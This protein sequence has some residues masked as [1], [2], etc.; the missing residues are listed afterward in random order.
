VDL[1]ENFGDLRKNGFVHLL[2]ERAVRCVTLLSTGETVALKTYRDASKVNGGRY[3]AAQLVRLQQQQQFPFVVRLL[4]SFAVLPTM[5]EN[6]G[7]ALMLEQ[8]QALPSLSSMSV[9]LVES[10]TNQ[11][12]QALAVLHQHSIVHM[13]IKPANL[14]L[15]MDSDVMNGASSVTLKL[16]DF[17]FATVLIPHDGLPVQGT[18]GY[19][20]PELQGKEKK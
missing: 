16:I 1:E 13:D 11:L 20:A 19:I 7:Y 3:E 9:P 2:T 15:T 17:E 8:L 6:W 14:M 18:K 4:D 12:L 10:I 5:M